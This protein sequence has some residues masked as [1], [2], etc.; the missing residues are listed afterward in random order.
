M[1]PATIVKAA[2]HAKVD[3]IVLATHGKTSMEAFWAGSVTHSICSRSKIPLLLI[4]VAKSNPSS[5]L[6]DKAP[7]N[8]ISN[9]AMVKGRPR[10]NRLAR[11]R[12]FWYYCAG[13]RKGET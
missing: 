12:R 3:L 6:T 1:T 7:E 8:L 4:P 11:P 10:E 2:A 5:G 13:C 9:A